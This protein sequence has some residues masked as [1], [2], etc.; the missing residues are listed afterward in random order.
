MSIINYSVLTQGNS[1][2][3]RAFSIPLAEELE[4]IDSIKTSDSPKKNIF[5]VDSSIRN[6]DIAVAGVFGVLLF[7]PG[8]FAIKVLD[9]LYEIKIKPKIQNIIKKADDIEIFKSSKKF[10]VHSLSIYHEELNVL[11]IVAAK[12]KG[13][14]ELYGSIEQLNNFTQ[15]AL[16]NLKVS[17]QKNQ[18]HLYILTEGKINLVPFIHEDIESASRQINS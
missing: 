18:V 17:P 1:S 3:I 16:H 14:D 6:N 7:L 10:F 11:V 12:E 15:V 5:V 9:D 8:W 4:K 2:F 13:L